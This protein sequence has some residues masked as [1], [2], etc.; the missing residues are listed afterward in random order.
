MTRVLVVTHE[1]IDRRMAGPAI[2]AFELARQLARA[3]HQVT[4]A[5]PLPSQLETSALALV[6]YDGESLRG[7]AGRQDV[8]VVQGWLLDRHPWLRE[9]PACLVVDLYD[10]FPLEL[11]ANIAAEPTP[12][13]IEEQTA[14]LRC[15]IEQ[16]RQGDY[17]I[18]ASERQLDFW[19]GMLMALNRVNPDTYVDDPTLRSLIDVVPFGVPSEPPRRQAPAMR[20]VLPGVGQDDLVLLWG[21]G[22]Y[23]WFDPATLIRAV[24]I[25]VRRHPALRLVFLGTSH[26]NPG[27]P[28]VAAL[29]GARRLSADMGLTGRH[30]FFNE[31]WVPYD[32]RADWL[33]EA[34]VGVSIHLDHLETRFSFRTRMLDYL[35]AGLPVIC[36]A[37]DT[38]AEEVDRLRLGRTVPPGDPE[39]IVAA[40][41]ELA[42]R[43]LRAVTA[44]RVRRF[45]VGLTWDRAAEPLVR[46]CD[47]PHR[48]PDLHHGSPE[49]LLRPA[50]GSPSHLAAPPAGRRATL[51]RVLIRAGEVLADDGPRGLASRGWRRL[52]RRLA[53][54]AAAF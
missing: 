9:V 31:G 30:V 27:V 18:C 52:K 5:T 50:V 47:R 20:E 48:A 45:A 17:L 39:A 23:N 34:D 13:R 19:L 8:I 38:L 16:V 49:V 7:L 3:G 6:S 54:S 14:A 15:L 36:T 53:R 10:P 51:S 33:L 37:G 32:R 44:D 29:T 28:E 21:G 2:R 42:D 12:S 1:P 25:A 43:Q 22:V 24:A 4:L 35:W 26:P 11:L 40:I 46:Y 41:D